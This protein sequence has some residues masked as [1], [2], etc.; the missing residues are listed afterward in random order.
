M[1]KATKLISEELDR[2]E[3]NYD[4]E[5][6]ENAS[7]LVVGFA[8]ENGPSVRVGFISADD[9]NSVAIRIIGLV[10]NIHDTKLDQVLNVVNNCNKKYRYVKFT[11]NEKNMNVEFDMPKFTP[12]N[13]VGPVAVEM[14]VRMMQIV[15][16]AYPEIMRAIWM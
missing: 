7:M 6:G 16:T 11:L 5:E 8:I 3:I 2:R 15:E 9:D 12:D 4:I 1:F 13:A 14:L 10:R